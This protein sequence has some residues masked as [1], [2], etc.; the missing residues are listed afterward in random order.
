MTVSV[1]DAL[2]IAMTRC[3]QIDSERPDLTEIRAVAHL[4]LFPNGKVQS[5]WFEGQ[6]RADSDP[7]FAYVLETIRLAIDACDP[8]GMLPRGEY[9]NWK[10]VQLTFFPTAKVVE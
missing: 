9:E 3:W 8:F 5:Y 2:R 6:S 7:A 4:K 1:V 10:S